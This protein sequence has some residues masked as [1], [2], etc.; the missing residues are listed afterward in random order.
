MPRN[1]IRNFMS[2]AGRTKVPK[3]STPSN[4]FN[5]M[6]DD[7][8]RQKDQLPSQRRASAE[9]GRRKLPGGDL[10][11]MS[12]SERAQT[13]YREMRGEGQTP[14]PTKKGAAASRDTQVKATARSRAPVTMKRDV[15]TRD[16][17]NTRATEILMSNRNFDVKPSQA[18]RTAAL[19]Q[20]QAE[21][22]RE[23]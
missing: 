16:R 20:A 19:R 18:Q 9:Y 21:I 4:T 12:S 5:K 17:V 3:K 6:S 2:L 11:G 15:T 7:L 1:R 13:V 10:Y 14:T 23:D 8:Q 22:D